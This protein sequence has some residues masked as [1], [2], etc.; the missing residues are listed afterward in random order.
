MTFLAWLKTKIDNK[1][2]ENHALDPVKKDFN[3]FPYVFIS[4]PTSVKIVKLP[5]W[6]VLQ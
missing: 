5:L 1:K 2:K 6:N 3:V 4:S